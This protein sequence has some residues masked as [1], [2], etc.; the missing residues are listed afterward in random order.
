M[1]I[2]SILLS[3]AVAATLPGCGDGENAAPMA[4]ADDIPVAH[5][6]PGGY[7]DVMPPAVLATW[8]RGP[9]I[10]QNANQ[11][12]ATDAGT[13][14]LFRSLCADAGVTPQHFVSR[15]DLGCGSTIGPITAARLG[16]PTV[17]VGNPMLSMHSCRE[18]AGSADVEPMIRVLRRFLGD[19][20]DA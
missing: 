19:A 9:V 12:Y 10:K 11:A 17:D 13:A 5:T 14:A 4:L 2:A 1:R 20:S 7:G 3:I 8:T 16:I 18:Q 6:P 15:S